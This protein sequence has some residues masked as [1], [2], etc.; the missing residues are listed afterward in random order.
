MSCGVEGLDGRR[1][2][3]R[4]VQV[5]GVLFVLC[6]SE[7]VAGRWELGPS[8]VLVTSSHALGSDSSEVVSSWRL[9]GF[10]GKLWRPRLDAMRGR[11]TSVVEM[12]EPKWLETLPKIRAYSLEQKGDG[13]SSALAS[14]RIPTDLQSLSLKHRTQ[15]RGAAIGAARSAQRSHVVQSAP[16]VRNPRSGGFDG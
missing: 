2:A 15:R 12:L 13:L 5:G 14:G 1:E 6:G 3:P 9:G 16:D 11:S 7:R 4:G 10:F 8:S